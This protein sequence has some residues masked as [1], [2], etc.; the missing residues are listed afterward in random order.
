MSVG[1]IH[2]TLVVGV[3]NAQ[4]SLV[5][6]LFRHDVS[7]FTNKLILSQLIDQIAFNIAREDGLRVALCH[8]SVSLFSLLDCANFEFIHLGYINF[9]SI[10]CAPEQSLVKWSHLLV[11]R[12]LC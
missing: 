6:V 8:D 12:D 4:I 10:I 11:I 1:L 5:S 2:H 7:N 3:K 9:E